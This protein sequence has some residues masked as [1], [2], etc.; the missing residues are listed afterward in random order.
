MIE[1]VTASHDDKVLGENLLRS[2]AFIYVR[3]YIQSG[4]D[5]IS[6][7]YNEAKTKCITVYVHHDVYLPPQF[8]E[9]IQTALKQMQSI[10][11]NWGVIGV[12]GV[13]LIDGKKQIFGNINDRGKEWGAPLPEPTEVDTLDEMLL[14]THGDFKF[15]E[16]LPQDFYGS[17]ICMQA[18]QQGRKNYVVNAYCFHNSSRLL[19]ARTESFYKSQE[20]F[21]NKWK[22]YLPLATTCALLS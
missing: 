8:I 12:C 10:D 7:A 15:D 6:K 5:N 2:D 14:I 19:G 4:Y 1:F 17:D 11:A 3:L 13:K 22:E 16:N 18:K 20:Y 9:D 21:K